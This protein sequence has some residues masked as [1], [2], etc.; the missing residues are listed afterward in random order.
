MRRN[1]QGFPCSTVLGE[2]SCRDRTETPFPAQHP[3]DAPPGTSRR[4]QP[5]AP[6]AVCQTNLTSQHWDAAVGVSRQY[7]DVVGNS[8]KEA[9][10]AFAWGKEVEPSIPTSLVPSVCDNPTAGAGCC[11]RSEAP[12][13]CRVF[14]SPLGL[15]R[16][17]VGETAAPLPQQ[18]PLER[19]HPSSTARPA[20][21]P[22]SLKF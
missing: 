22:Q 3:R 6:T 17:R 14:S 9:F 8:A 13:A 4:S 7:N 18:Q 2:D 15:G 10:P 1:S 5:R 20:Y 11:Q 19:F 21:P 12:S 16:E